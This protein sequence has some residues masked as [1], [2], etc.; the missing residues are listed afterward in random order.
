MHGVRGEDRIMSGVRDRVMFIIRDTV[1]WRSEAKDG[2]L[3]G[4]GEAHS[5]I[6]KG[7]IRSDWTL[8]W[9][10]GIA[11]VTSRVRERK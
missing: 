9:G 6:R 2:H 7:G 4:Q 11:E 10:L 5:A 8:R 3:G 1:G